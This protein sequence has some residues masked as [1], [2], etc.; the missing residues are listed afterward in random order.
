MIYSAKTKKY[1]RHTSGTNF[2]AGKRAFPALNAFFI[3]GVNTREV[4]CVLMSTV[5]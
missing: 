3:F 1:G 4:L 2:H 5:Y